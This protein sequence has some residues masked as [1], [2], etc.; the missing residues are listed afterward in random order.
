[1]YFISILG[2]RMNHARWSDGWTSLHLAAMLGVGDVIALLLDAGADASIR[3]T[4]GVFAADVATKYGFHDVADIIR[5]APRENFKQEAGLCIQKEDTST[6]KQNLHRIEHLATDYIPIKKNQ[7]IFSFDEMSEEVVW[8]LQ[9]QK[10]LEETQK[11]E[12]LECQKKNNETKSSSEDRDSQLLSETETKNKLTQAEELENIEKAF[13]EKNKRR[14]EHRQNKLRKERAEQD[15]KA[16]RDA[17]Y[18]EIIWALQIKKELSEES[19][20]PE[21]AER[22]KSL[23]QIEEE[24]KDGTFERQE[25]EAQNKRKEQIRLENI[26]KERKRL[27]LIIQEA[28]N[29]RE[30]EAAQRK[31]EEQRELELKRIQLDEEDAKKK[32]QRLFDSLPK[33]RR[34]LNLQLQEEENRKQSQMEITDEQ[35]VTLLKEQED[36]ELRNQHFSDEISNANDEE[37][38]CRLPKWK[39]E[40]KSR[41]KREKMAAEQIEKDIK[42][43]DNKVLEQK[44]A[45]INTAENDDPSTADSKESSVNCNSSE[46]I[47]ESAAI[48]SLIAS[49]KEVTNKTNEIVSS[50]RLSKNDESAA[51]SCCNYQTPEEKIKAD[52]STNSKI[53]TSDVKESQP[54]NNSHFKIKVICMILTVLILLFLWIFL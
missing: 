39:I 26:S 23:I 33:W 28:E 2:A 53:E 18:D 7:D 8:A 35:A 21:E 29:K 45:T 11:K 24:K 12:S 15:E 38:L 3:D 54:K 14:R 36:L 22:Y 49:Q 43:N 32:E 10:E 4:E 50:P 51:I 17:M 42:E 31:L 16:L 19:G 6:T 30:E 1:M 47:V 20:L 52:I 46:S 27:A 34:E 44:Y 13:K 41:L 9:M 25:K 48:Q 5:R 37:N 40:Y